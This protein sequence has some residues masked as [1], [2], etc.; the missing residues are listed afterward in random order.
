MSEIVL[1]R[2]KGPEEQLDQQSSSSGR[3][4][5]LALIHPHGGV[6]E[7]VAHVLVLQA[8]QG[9]NH[10]WALD[11]Q[12][13]ETPDGRHLKLLNV[14]DEFTPEALACVVGRSMDSEGVVGAIERL[15]AERGAPEHL[16]LDDGPELMPGPARPHR[17]LRTG[18][19]VGTCLC[20]WRA[21]GWESLWLSTSHTSTIPIGARA[22][23]R[24]DRNRL[25][26][27]GAT[28]MIVL[29]SRGAGQDEGDGRD[30]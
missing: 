4:R 3:Q 1:E 24:F 29:T 23:A 9:P 15:T 25:P 12:F 5:H 26:A 2:R 18:L 16:R 30:G 27:G 7:R 21:S 13:D 28:R 20:T 11:F 10:V 8:A 19:R 22:P 6:P 14:V 17:S